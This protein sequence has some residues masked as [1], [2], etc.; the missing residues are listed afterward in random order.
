MAVVFSFV[1]GRVHR[2]GA[3]TSRTT[4]VTVLVGFQDGARGFSHLWRSPPCIASSHIVL[5]LVFV[6]SRSSVVMTRPSRGW[7]IQGIW[8]LPY[9]VLDHV[10]W[11][12]WPPCPEDNP[13][14]Q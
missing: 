14:P 5:E 10:L 11:Q 12:N 1:G 7:V 3:Y 13:A 4:S 2:D 8:H 9:S 6:P